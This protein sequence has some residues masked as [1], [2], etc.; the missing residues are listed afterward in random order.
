MD[1]RMATAGTNAAAK[2]NG[3][4]WLWKEVTGIG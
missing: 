2:E 4:G 1:A 3:A